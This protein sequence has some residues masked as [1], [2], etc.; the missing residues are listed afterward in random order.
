MTVRERPN[1]KNLDRATS[2]ENAAVATARTMAR[3][4]QNKSGT[5]YYWNSLINGSII[6]EKNAPCGSAVGVALQLWL[7]L[8]KRGHVEFSTNIVKSVNWLLAN[9]YNENHPDLNLAGKHV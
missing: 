6:T 4:Q 3:A 2:Y 9:Q 7:R 1:N 8:Y 5:I